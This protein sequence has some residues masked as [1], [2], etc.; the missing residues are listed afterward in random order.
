MS[1]RTR[2]SIWFVAAVGWATLMWFVVFPWIDESL[3]SRPAL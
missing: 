2:W 1:R 3:I